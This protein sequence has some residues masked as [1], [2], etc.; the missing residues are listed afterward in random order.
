MRHAVRDERGQRGKREAAH[1]TDEHVD[2]V[3]QPQHWREKERQRAE[4]L[5]GQARDADALRPEARHQPLHQHKLHHGQRAAAQHQQQAHLPRLG[6]ELLDHEQ[7]RGAV[8]AVEDKVEQA[9][10]EQQPAQPRLARHLR[11]G[12]QRVEVAGADGRGLALIARQRLGQQEEAQQHVDQRKPG[13]RKCGG[14]Q[15][16]LAEHGPQRRAE[17]QP[18]PPRHADEGEVL[19]ALRGLGDIGNIGRG[20]GQIAAR[21]AADEPPQEQHPQRAA[22]AEH[23][24]AGGLAHQAHQ[25]DRPA[26][27]A[28]AELAHQRRGEKLRSG[29]DHG[30]HGDHQRF[31]AVAPDDVRRDGQEHAEA[32]DVH[33][34][35]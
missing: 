22:D 26:P 14:F 12:H 15:A 24:I 18:Q 17:D 33:Q 9:Q 5:P 31:A 3:E 23:C 28:V 13:R 29:V 2:R 27:V 35:D 21:D 8:D 34:H 30:D 11:D 4:R 1:G 20:G 10:H 6:G 16:D 25:Q 32:D 19:G 7:G